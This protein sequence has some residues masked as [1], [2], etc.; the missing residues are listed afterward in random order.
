LNKKI[1]FILLILLTVVLSTGVISAN[2]TNVTDSNITSSVDDISIT[3]DNNISISNTNDD[4]LSANNI[5]NDVTTLNSTDLSKTIK[6]DNITIYYKGNTPYTAVFSD[7]NGNPIINTSVNI[8]VN[9]VLHTKTTDNNGTVSLSINL[10]PGTYNIVATNP[11]TGYNLTT[12]F[13]ILSTISSVDISKVYTDN[14]YFYAT[15]YKNTGQVLANTYV[16]FNIAGKTYKVKTN[17]NGVASLSLKTLK[18]GTYTITIYN[19]DG[20]TKTNKV[21]VVK[22]TTTSL[23]S[24]YYTFLKSESTKKVKVKLLN[25]LGYA[26]QKG[27]IV[28]ITINGKTYSKKT[29]KNGYASLKLPSLKKGI[30]KIKYK[31]AG[32]SY[33]K[34]SSS[35]NKVA[36]IPSKTPTFTVKS[37]TNF[38]EGSKATFK[39]AVTSGSVPLQKRTITFKLNGTSYTKTTNNDGIASISFNLDLGKYPVS[40]SIAGDSKIN[41]KS[42]NSTIVVKEKSTIIHNGYWIFGRDMNNVNLNDLSSQGVSDVFLNFFAYNE[43]GKSAV[44]SWVSNA[45]SKGINVHLWAQVFYGGGEWVNPVVNG[46]ENTK[47]FEE[48]ISELKKYANIK[49]IAGIHLDYLRYPGTAYKTSG[50]ADAITSFTKQAVNAIKGIDSSIIVSCALMPETTDNKYYYGQDYNALTQVL[51]V[52]IPMIYKGNYH[53]GTSWITKTTKWFVDNSKGASVWSGIQTYVSDDN[54]T[55]LSLSE[56]KGDVDAAYDGGANGV[57]LFRYGISNSINF[58]TAVAAPLSSGISINSI[59]AGANTIKSYYSSNKKLPSSVTAGGYTF[60][61]PEFLYLMGQAINQLG[62]NNTGDVVII[63][64]ISA[65]TSP[66]G[67]N[68]FGDLALKDFLTVAK[69]L[70]NFMVSNNRAPNYSSS[71]LGNIIYTEVVDAFSRILS[72][73]GLN[74]RLP[75]YCTISYGSVSSGSGSGLNEKN[76]IKDLSAYLKSTTNCPISNSKIKSIV[77]SVTKGL[78]TDAQKAK[79][80]YNYVRDSISYTFYSNTRY[81]AVKTLTNKKGNCVD[82]AHLLVAMFRCAGLAARYVHGSCK[83]TSGS[84]YGHVWAQVLIDN[85]WTCA[86]PTSSKNSL[87]KI[88]NWNTKTFT[89]KA[90]YASLPF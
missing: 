46:K 19:P 71:S 52:V 13:K 61:V 9:G 30:Y 72:F 45:N 12:T 10:Q 81:G 23:T 66:S 84:T 58:N 63:N 15:F 67:D 88:S 42:V 8:S 11:K 76:T 68:I 7:T 55:K 90:K 77:A 53:A 27:K 2:D 22:S 60:T 49:G 34:A 24:S 5:D 83:F 3:N 80:I 44:E 64:G 33:Y 21:K 87:G 20:L 29:N 62:K 57:I 38:A 54:P 35:S 56:L 82:Q 47:Y 18:K 79:A 36:I 31:F 73:Y 41:A 40:Y 59:I 6:A 26:P 39:V 32:N 16:K 70:V 75:N 50:G 4:T 37:G 86:D 69:N 1:L 48:K 43:Y 51:D 17:N 85:V 78:T 28:K 74:G 25:G 65:P 89:L 14:R